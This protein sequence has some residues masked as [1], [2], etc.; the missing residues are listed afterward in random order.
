MLFTAFIWG[1]GASCGT[2][3]GAILFCFLFRVL[4]RCCGPSP[5]AAKAISTNEKSL[6]ALIRRNKLSESVADAARLYVALNRKE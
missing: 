1:L 2:A 3:F 5:N 4:D 6:E